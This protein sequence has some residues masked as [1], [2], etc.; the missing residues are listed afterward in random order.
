MAAIV[1]SPTVALLRAPLASRTARKAP[2]GGISQLR[3]AARPAALGRGRSVAVRASAPVD[4]VVS[5]VNQAIPQVADVFGVDTSAADTVFVNAASI[6][7]PA[8][9]AIVGA[10]FVFGTIYKIAFPDKYNEQVYS[11]KAAEMVQDEMIDLDNLSEEDLAAVAE[12]EAER[13]AQK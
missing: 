13:A 6:I 1:S 11:G 2:A 10:I 8:W 5:G 9:G 12:L 3:S 4:S 7:L